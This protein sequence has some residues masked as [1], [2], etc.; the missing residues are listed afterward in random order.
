MVSVDTNIGVGAIYGYVDIIFLVMACLLILDSY[1]HTDV[2]FDLQIE[3]TKNLNDNNKIP[4]KLLIVRRL[5]TLIDCV[6]G[7]NIHTTTH[8]V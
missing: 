1:I 7:G 3:I 6:G 5:M 8:N 2:L 4:T